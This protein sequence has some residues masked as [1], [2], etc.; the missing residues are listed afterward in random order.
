MSVSDPN[1]PAPSALANVRTQVDAQRRGKRP[2]KRWRA[3][4]DW[5]GVLAKIMC[6]GFAIIGL[7]P[8]ALGG[9]VRTDRVQQWAA[10]RTAELLER[11]LGVNARYDLELVLW[12]L[13]LAMENVDVPSNDGGVSFLRAQSVLARPR[14]FTLLAGKLDFGDVE[15]EEPKLR[16]IVSLGRLVNL[17]YQLPESSRDTDG[18]DLPVSALALTNGDI[19]LTIDDTRI[20][21]HEI[22]ID[23][24]IAPMPSDRKPLIAGGLFEI[25]I[26]A[27]PTALDHT[28]SDPAAPELEQVN[29]DAFCSVELRAQI[30]D[31]ILLRRLSLDG[32]VDFDP[33]RGTRPPCRVAEGDWRKISLAVEGLHVQ[34]DETNTLERLDGRLKARAPIAL[35]HRFVDF[36]GTSGWIDVD[37]DNIHLDPSVTIPALRGKIQGRGIGIDGRTVAHYL[38]ANIS[39]AANVIDLS[40]LNMG[41]GGGNVAFASIRLKPLEKGMPLE[42]KGVD[43][44][45]ITIQDMLDDLGTHPRAHVAWSLYTAH[46]PR[47]GGTLDPL[48]LSGPITAQTRDF[49]VFNEPFY[50]KA[51]RKFMGVD[52]AVLTGTVRVEPYGIVL[53]HMVADTGRSRVAATIG[54]HYDS[55]LGL[56]IHEGSFVD[57]AD[58][59]PLVDIPMKG[60]AH[61][62]LGGQSTFD[63]PRFAGTLRVDQFDFAGFAIGDVLHSKVAFKPLEFMLT[64]GRLRKNKSVMD[65]PQLNIDF[66]DGDADLVMQGELDTRTGG[67]RI[68]DFFE[69]MGLVSEEGPPT[70]AS[71]QLDPQWDK[72][73]ALARGRA[74]IHYVLGGKRDRCASGN[75][76]VRAKMTVDDVKLWGLSFDSGDVDVD[77]RWEDMRAG[78]QGL[79]VRLKSGVLRKGTGTVIASASVDP[80]AK[81]RVDVVGSAI[82]LDEL[83][84]FRRAFDVD[85]NEKLDVEQRVRPEAIVSFVATVGGTLARLTGQADVDISPTRIGPDILPASRFSVSLVPEDAPVRRVATSRCGNAITAPFDPQRWASDPQGGVVVLAGQLFGEQISFSDLQVTQQRNALVSGELDLRKLNLGAFANLR[86]GVAFSESPPR[87][88]L[89]AQVVVD[90]LPLD[91]PGLA[92][93]RIFIKALEGEQSGDEIHIGAV[94]EPVVLSGDA[95]RIPNM[96]IATRLSS[97][98]EATF[99]AGG[100]VS[101]LSKATPTLAV[102]LT[103]DP[104]DLSKLGVELPQV[105]RAQGTVRATMA[106]NGTLDAPKLS[107]RVD[108]RNA[109]LRVKGVPVPFDDI[110]IDI[111]IDETEARIHRASARVGNT[112]QLAMSGRMPLHNL[113]VSGGEAT[114]VATDVKLPVADG[115]KLTADARLHASYDPKQKGKLALPNITGRITIKQLQYTRAMNFQ[116][117]VGA[118]V[119]DQITSKRRSVAT[120]NPADDWIRFDVAL[121]SPEPVR[122]A[123]NLLDMSLEVKRPGIQVSGTNQRFGARGTLAIEPGSK[124]FLQRHQFKVRD[125][126]ITFDN[127]TRI[128]PSLDVHATTEYRRYQTSSGSA[129]GA[130]TSASSTTSTGGRWRISMHASGEL[131][132]PEVRFTSDPPLSQEDIV[133]LLQVGQTRAELERGLLSGIGQGVAL[134]ALSAVTGLDKAFKDVP[135]IDEFRVGSQ[136]SS[137]TGRPEPTV[138]FGKRLTDS[139]RATLT[140]GLSENR[141]V[142]SSIEW[143]LK[144][145][146][147]LQGSYD[148][149][150]EVSSSGIGNI[151]G[152][153]RYRFEFE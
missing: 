29:E 15:I 85:A 117:T 22:D 18:Q 53:S 11:E 138:T 127:P 25:S 39:A 70:S 147:S 4:R 6:I 77:Y 24:A 107:G 1:P 104:I 139:V 21:S 113:S 8:L 9:L 17:N 75:L 102:S 149:V 26:R 110:N 62:Q 72:L 97:G 130:T 121:V 120:Y 14:L 93:V 78:A 124:L 87:G 82:P 132:A 48:G 90:E 33:T 152:G 88:R 140:T 136:Y 32:A 125:G 46:F 143:Q 79:T 67:M 91:T 109:M 50:A 30:S 47:F 116:P 131:E 96:L 5:G 42:A 105:D 36:P 122:I 151:G 28:Q 27:G 153:I 106:V 108:L 148:N 55:V 114:L 94:S 40:E 144:G 76:D 43:F 86:Q 145:G 111:R 81:V 63:D 118:V 68:R 71:P 61:L 128:A 134:E 31:T 101:N 150:N 49:A 56:A 92:E 34:L 123:N 66:D 115:V 100:T 103:L 84:G 126:A 64:E 133:L 137:R 119:V 12:P 13:E 135:I 58:V 52:R 51:K 89:T 3:R 19:D 57:L 74:Q 38:R 65:V 37:L 129:T 99:W 35:V 146:V 73:D 83:E 41:W 141:E 112:G 142:R 20:R 59:S 60:I 54:L 80:G 7:V 10:T 2:K 44:D 95:L 69:I 23:V 45:D 98:L 16:A